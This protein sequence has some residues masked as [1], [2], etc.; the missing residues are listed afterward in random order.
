MF[1]DTDTAIG[2]G[3]VSIPMIIM[4]QEQKSHVHL[5]FADFGKLLQS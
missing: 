3:I 1:Q 5:P 4:F 2:S